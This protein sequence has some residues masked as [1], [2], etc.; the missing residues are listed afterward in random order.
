MAALR[1]GGPRDKPNSACHAGK[2]SD[3]DPRTENANA[4]VRKPRKTT[5]QRPASVDASAWGRTAA[6][7]SLRGGS[8]LLDGA[9]ELGDCLLNPLEV[10]VLADAQRSN[11]TC[12]GKNL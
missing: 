4:S 6:M 8:D 7:A 2:T 11:E 1:E 5:S 12:L 9:R 10:G 3:S